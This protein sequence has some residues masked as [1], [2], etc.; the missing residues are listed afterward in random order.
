MILDLNG[1]VFRRQRVNNGD[2]FVVQQRR[3][4]AKS[5]SQRK[6]EGGLHLGRSMRIG[7]EN[8]KL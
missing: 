2:G 1:L 7:S 4:C 8:H 3:K 5:Q 6:E